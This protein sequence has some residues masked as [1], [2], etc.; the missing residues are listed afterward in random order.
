MRYSRESILGEILKICRALM[1]QETFDELLVVLLQIMQKGNHDDFTKQT[2]SGYIQDVILENVQLMTPKNAKTTAQKVV[3]IF[4]Q[5]TVQACL[6]MKDTLVQS[7]ASCLGLQFKV[8]REFPKT[9]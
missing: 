6:S 5:R 2:A 8:L 1:T 3:Q 9:V 7:Y 4:E